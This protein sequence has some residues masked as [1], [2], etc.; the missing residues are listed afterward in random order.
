[1]DLKL[2]HG[3]INRWVMILACYLCTLFWK[4]QNFGTR[5]Q[6]EASFV[7][8][9]PLRVLGTLGARAGLIW[10]HHITLEHKLH[11]QNSLNTS[12]YTL[13][14]LCLTKTT[15][16]HKKLKLFK[17]FETLSIAQ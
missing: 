6:K 2:A 1:M 8:H 3:C 11:F 9:V 16:I 14:N 5:T 17:S 7:K 4:I 12:S 13:L 15:R 10:H